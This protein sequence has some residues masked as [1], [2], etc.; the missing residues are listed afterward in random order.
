[1][2][3]YFAIFHNGKSLELQ[4]ES[5]QATQ[6]TREDELHDLE[7]KLVVLLEEQE[8]EIQQIKIR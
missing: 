6:R 7:Q 1:M 3:K 8:I 2:T 4:L 5:I